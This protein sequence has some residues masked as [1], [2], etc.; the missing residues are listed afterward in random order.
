MPSITN[1]VTINLVANTQLAAG[2][3]AAMVYLPDEGEAMAQAGEA[4]YINMGTIFPIYEETLYF[5]QGQD[6]NTGQLRPSQLTLPLC[7]Q[8]P[9]L[10]ASD[11]KGQASLAE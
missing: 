1:T 7:S 4:L 8:Q 10:Y 2:G 5:V 9:I 3:S 11:F 6:E